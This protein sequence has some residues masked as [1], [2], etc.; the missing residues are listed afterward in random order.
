MTRKQKQPTCTA[1]EAGTN[2]LVSTPMDK[3]S[4]AM[5]NEITARARTHDA[6]DKLIKTRPHVRNTQS[7]VG[8]GN[9]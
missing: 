6:N 3:T 7:R 5:R 8:N 2:N 9:S 1:R 4:N